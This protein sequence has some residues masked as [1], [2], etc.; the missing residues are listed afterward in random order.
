MAL[1]DHDNPW[2]FAG[3]GDSDDNDKGENQVEYHYRTD[4]K[5]DK[6]KMPARFY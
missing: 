5:S 6:W 1:G 2:I 3:D 4:R